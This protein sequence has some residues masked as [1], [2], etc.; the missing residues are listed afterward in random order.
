MSKQLT[1]IPIQQLHSS[2]VQ[3]VKP[4]EEN[5]DE[6]FHLFAVQQNSI[7][8]NYFNSFS[9]GFFRLFF[10]LMQKSFQ[11]MSLVIW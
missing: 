2:D 7:G 10:Y 8:H 4:P 6:T 1:K 11:I 5:P 3:N 9:V